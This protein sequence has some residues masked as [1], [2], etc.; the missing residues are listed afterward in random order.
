MTASTRW[1]AMTEP[2]PAPAAG[3]ADSRASGVAAR[4]AS[5]PVGPREVYQAVLRGFA[6]AGKPPEPS[7]LEAVARPSGL[8]VGQLLSELVAADLL[9]LDDAGRIRMAYPFSTRPT[10]HM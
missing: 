2:D 4:F 8:A 3:A 7:E 6:A 9:G 10:P 1:A 5:L